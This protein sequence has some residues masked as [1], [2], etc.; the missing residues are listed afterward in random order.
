MNNF[1]LMCWDYI[2]SATKKNTV[3]WKKKL[4]KETSHYQ[5]IKRADAS[6]IA[7]R[8]STQ[9]VCMNTE[10]VHTTILQIETSY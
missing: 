2:Y 3:K 8:G 7:I 6:F 4:H 5:L 10:S 1:F 9:T